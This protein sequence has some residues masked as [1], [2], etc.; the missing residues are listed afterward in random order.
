MRLTETVIQRIKPTGTRVIYSDSAPGRIAGFQLIVGASGRRTFY[1]RYRKDGRQI[2][3]QIGEYGC[4]GMD[5]ATARD[6]A[7]QIVRAARGFG[8]PA[9]FEPFST[10]PAPK[11]TGPTVNEVYKLYVEFSEASKRASTVSSS[12]RSIEHHLIP[13]V[14]TMPM[15][16]VEKS[17]VRNVIN[18]LTR[19]GKAG[20]ASTCLK[21]V[22]AF[23]SWSLSE[24]YVDTHC[25]N[26]LRKPQADVA[27]DRI[28]SDDE[29][30]AVMLAAE[31]VPQGEGVILAL[32]TGMRQQEI[33]GGRWEWVSFTDATYTVPALKT[34]TGVQYVIPLSEWSVRILQR[35]KAN[36]TT[37]TAWIF[38]HHSDPS[39]CFKSVFDRVRRISDMSGVTGWSIRDARR[40]FATKLQASTSRD[41]CDA[42]LN[43]ARTG[44]AKN[45][46]HHSY[47]DEVRSAVEGWARKLSVLTSGLTAVN[48]R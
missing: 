22:K 4:Y 47:T 9:S 2:Q 48:E 31:E 12:R 20:V 28:L 19:D 46:L 33:Y 7:N 14:G 10:A 6:R 21:H 18:G 40:T 13:A 39:R 34:K 30:K 42:A 25:C 26:G 24:G 37:P 5:L 43:H 29:I 45:Y 36:Q 41:V 16:A 15:K 8:Q 35:I 1:V 44:L 32:L 11:P 27:L 23:F 38:P 3:E 17:N